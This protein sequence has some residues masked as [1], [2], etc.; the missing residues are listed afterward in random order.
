MTSLHCYSDIHPNQEIPLRF[1]PSK[2][3]HSTYIKRIK[4]NYCEKL[5]PNKFNVLDKMD[6][7]L[8]THKLPGVFEKEG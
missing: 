6:N 8:E 3:Y 2:T 5:Y 4:N 1:F 7:F